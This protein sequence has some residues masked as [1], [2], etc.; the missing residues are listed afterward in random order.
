MTTMSMNQQD[1]NS[2]AELTGGIRK[3]IGLKFAPGLTVA[4]ETM[5]G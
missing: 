4:L 3:L 2:A 5:T 1:C